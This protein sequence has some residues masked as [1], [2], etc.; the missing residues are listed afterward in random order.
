MPRMPK[1]QSSKPLSAKDLLENRYYEKY[2]SELSEERDNK[3]YTSKWYDEQVV[4]LNKEYLEVCNKA[5][6]NLNSRISEVLKQINS[7]KEQH[8]SYTPTDDEI[9]SINYAKDLI[10][11]RLINETKFNPHAADKIINEFIG[12]RTGASAI[13]QLASDSQV[14]EYISA[15]VFAKAY[16]KSIPPEQVK[17]EMEKDEKL[18]KLETEF[19]DLQRQ[20]VIFSK[21]LEIA[22]QRCTD[23]YTKQ[24]NDYYFK[25]LPTAE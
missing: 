22:E 23:D 24:V 20:H 15:D 16:A 5:M 21:H 17:F 13:V 25:Q 8:F 7:V 1:F 12:S 9:R 6:K 18:N 11:S 3:G 10:K 19:I 14:E 4:K 2:L